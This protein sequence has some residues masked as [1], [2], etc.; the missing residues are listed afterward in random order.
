MASY[1]SALGVLSALREQLSTRMAVLLGGSPAVTLLG[2]QDLTSAPSG[3]A[4]GIYLHRMAV[5][6]FSRNRYLSPPDSR[7]SRQPE[8]PVN[9]HILLIGWSIKTESEINFLAAA[10]QAIGSALVLDSAH[11]ALS[12]PHWGNQDAVQVI[13]E[14]MSTEDLMRMW[15]S[16]PGDYR[17]SAPY[18]IKT[19]R[20]GPD[21][22]I[23]DEPLVETLVFPAGNAEGQK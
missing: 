18:I 17:L 21:K 16:L 12:D 20:L 3:E 13:P 8:L 10:M 2:S 4:L 5:D 15:D 11:L 7:R 22:L 14:E 6:P 19:L 1:R 9:F 23:A